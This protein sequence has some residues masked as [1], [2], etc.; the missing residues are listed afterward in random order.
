MPDRREL[1]LSTAQAAERADD[2]DWTDYV[3]TKVE[4]LNSGGFECGSEGTGW[5]LGGEYGVTPRVGDTIRLYGPFGRPIVGQD[6]NGE[7]IYYRTKAEEK[8]RHE[9]WV[10]DL[11]D[12]YRAEYEADKD[13]LADEL[14]G[15]PEPFQERIRRALADDPDWA[16]QGMGQRYEQFALV[17]AVK[18]HDH[19]NGDADAIEV[20]RKDD[21]WKRQKRK[22]PKL[23]EGMSG[24]QFG[25]A[26]YMAECL[27]RGIDV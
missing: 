22:G 5:I 9:Q 7:P 19:F 1:Q 13:R 15:L 12:R 11:H 16:W 4:P 24:N 21:D 2:S 14:S 23:D 3:L 20:W 26:G 10:A 18:I 17:Q 8:A 27:A 6:I 25:F